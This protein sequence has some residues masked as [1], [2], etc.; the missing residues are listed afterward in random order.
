MLLF[1]ASKLH[2]QN[3]NYTAITIFFG[4]DNLFNFFVFLVVFHKTYFNDLET[5]PGHV[6]Q[7]D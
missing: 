2:Q 1:I 6:T 5:V 3:H 7:Q 4:H